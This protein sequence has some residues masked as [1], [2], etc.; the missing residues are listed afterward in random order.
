MEGVADV[1]APV[2]VSD[3]EADGDQRSDGAEARAHA[4][5]DGFER[6]VAGARLRRVD[7]D[8]LGGAVVHGEEDGHLAV[9]LG[10]CGG[11]VGAP[12]LV[13]CLRD[14]GAVVRPW[15]KL[16]PRTAG[17]E[18]LRLAHQAEHPRSR[19]PHSLQRPEAGPDLPMSLAD[20]LGRRQVLADE[21]EQLLVGHLRLRSALA[22]EA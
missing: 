18:Q 22:H 21:R 19:G 15:S 16:S 7:A 4:L 10:E 11:R 8:A 6:L 13:R 2:V 1:L 20:P 3:R 17:R 14:D 9:L 12:H 5:V